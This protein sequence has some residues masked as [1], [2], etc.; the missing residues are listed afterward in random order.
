MV[1]WNSRQPLRSVV[2]PGVRDGELGYC[3]CVTI[4]YHTRT[5]VLHC[6]VEEALY[7]FTQKRK[8]PNIDTTTSIDPSID[9]EN[10]AFR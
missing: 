3:D 10:D 4:V 5:R 9:R 6:V 2:S 8:K 1:F 7:N